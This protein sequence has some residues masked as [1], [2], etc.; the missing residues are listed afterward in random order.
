VAGAAVLAPLEWKPAEA[1]ASGSAADVQPADAADSAPA[2]GLEPPSPA[3]AASTPAAGAISESAAGS[4]VESAGN[5]AEPIRPAAAS[6]AGRTRSKPSKHKTRPAD[7]LSSA[8]RSIAAADY[9]Q[10]AELYARLVRSGKHL[11]QVAADL[12]VATVAYPDVPQF[13][14]LLGQVRARAGD[15]QAA[16]ASYRRAMELQHE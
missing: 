3:P 14:K 16:L 5:G 2:A 12:D 11:D 1:A 7:W 6:R 8:R 10:A 4:A 15:V 9:A 13:H